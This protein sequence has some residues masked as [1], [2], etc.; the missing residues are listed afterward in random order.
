LLPFETVSREGCGASHPLTSV[1]ED[2]RRI[3]RR[4]DGAS[5]RPATRASSADR[6]V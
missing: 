6:D 3:P 1:D 2:G 5:R 4:S